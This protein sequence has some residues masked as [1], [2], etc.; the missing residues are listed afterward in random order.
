MFRNHINYVTTNVYLIPRQLI[1][2]PTYTPYF[3]KNQFP[4]VVQPIANK[5]DNLSSNLLL[6]KF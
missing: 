4:I 6:H 2:P 5:E 1:I 3:V